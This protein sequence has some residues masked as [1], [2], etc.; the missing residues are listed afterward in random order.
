VTRTSDHLDV[1]WADGAIM[2]AGVALSPAGRKLV[3]RAMGGIVPPSL[4]TLEQ[5]PGLLEATMDAFAGRPVALEHRES[6]LILLA[7]AKASSCRFCYAASRTSLTILG[8]S[9]EHIR[10]LDADF[11]APAMSERQRAVLDATALLTRVSAPTDTAALTAIAE[12]PGGDVLL[13]DVAAVTARSVLATRLFTLT[14]APV[15]PL[16]PKLSSWWTRP[17]RPLLRMMLFRQP[18][19]GAA[20]RKGEL[21]DGPL[22]AALATIGSTPT[23]ADLQRLIAI[24]MAG[25][26][27]KA[28]TK[29]LVLAVIARTLGCARAEAE[30]VA[31]S[32]RDD[33]TDIVDELGGGRVR[34]VVGRMLQVARASVSG[35]PATVQPAMQ[36]LCEELEPPAFAELLGSLVAGNAAV[37]LERLA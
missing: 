24:L 15:P 26:G 28:Q 32:G 2:P 17:L 36:K 29:A 30:L 14:A 8:M 19:A 13:Q 7:V 6:E 37:R 10:S 1:P 23:A 27:L 25:D 18:G 9:P 35:N 20:A 16:I 5:V 22:R 11:H 34:P 33:A 21:A 4:G 31:L 12:S 3:T